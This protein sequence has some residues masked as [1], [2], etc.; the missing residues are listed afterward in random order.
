MVETSAPFAC[1]FNG[2]RLLVLGGCSQVRK[3]ECAQF[4]T[5]A[6]DRWRHFRKR[7]EFRVLHTRIVRAG[8]VCGIY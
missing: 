1:R 6:A 5:V 4:S 8:H 2:S 7:A 3:E